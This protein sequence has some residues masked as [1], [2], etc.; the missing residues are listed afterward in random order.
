MSTRTPPDYPLIKRLMEE[1]AK[2]GGPKE[3]ARQLSLNK[4]L[5]DRNKELQELNNSLTRTRDSIQERI[6]DFEKQEAETNRTTANATIRMSPS[7]RAGRAGK[8]R[9]RPRGPTAGGGPV[10][11]GRD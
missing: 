2:Y 11:P 8:T 4:N 3:L 7:G 1:C 10:G 6:K 5:E 9:R